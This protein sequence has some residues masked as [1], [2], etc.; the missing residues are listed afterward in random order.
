MASNLRA[1]P[2]EGHITDSAGNV[3][4]NKKIVI[5][6]SS[7]EGSFS[8]D[9]TNSD[10]S[11]YFKTKPI[12]SGNYDVYESGI[13]LSRTIHSSDKSAI[14]SFKAGTDNVGGVNSTF[15]TLVGSKELNK[16]KAFLQIES[17]DLD[18]SQYGSSFPVYEKDLS[19]NNPEIPGFEELWNIAS[20]FGFNNLSRIT[21]TRFDIEYYSPIHALSSLYKRVRW[22]GVPGIK[23]FEDSKIVVP[24]DYYSIMLNHPKLISPQTGVYDTGA[25]GVPISGTSDELVLSTTT[26][27]VY[28]E[29]YNSL[30]VGDVIQVIRGA[31]VWYGIIVLKSASGNEITTEKLRSSR[32]LSTLDPTVVGDASN[33]IGFDGM[34][35]NITEIKETANEKFTVVENM[36]AQALPV[37]VYNYN[38]HTI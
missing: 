38:D 16:F 24:L 29:V 15:E 37:E 5:K 17:A 30:N 21:L 34:F 27:S 8:V 20:F 33:V 28:I 2:I 35:Q 1:K 10:D 3:L 12:P 6:Q 14:Q 4:R 7:P 26:N 9:S 13:L 25:N 23:F 32:F 19:Q 31:D 22:V 18:V 11:G 36:D